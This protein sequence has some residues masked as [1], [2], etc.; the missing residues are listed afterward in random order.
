MTSI[1]SSKVVAVWFNF[2]GTTKSTEQSLSG[3]RGSKSAGQ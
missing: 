2:Q 3:E 1:F